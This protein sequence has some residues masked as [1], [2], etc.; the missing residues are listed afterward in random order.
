M[1]VMFLH[2]SLLITTFIRFLSSFAANPATQFMTSLA[3]RF[4]EAT[5]CLLAALSFDTAVDNFINFLAKILLLIGIIIM[6][7]AGWSIHEGKIREGLMAL[8]GGL[9]V[10]LAIP[11]AK[12]IISL[13]F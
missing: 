9:I 4:D 11:L 13:G 7:W 3:D 10:A 6:L 5:F 12:W 1:S 2:V 8:I